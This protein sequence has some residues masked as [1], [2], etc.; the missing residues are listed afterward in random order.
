MRNRFRVEQHWSIR[1]E[2]TKGLIYKP[3][4]HE[5]KLYK[6]LKKISRELDRIAKL[7]R[8]R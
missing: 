8:P 5:I 3:T 6:L 4:E 2:C 7:E 1:L